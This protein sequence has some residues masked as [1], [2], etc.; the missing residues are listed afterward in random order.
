MSC[1]INC[2]NCRVTAELGP[3]CVVSRLWRNMFQIKLLIRNFTF[4]HT[5]THSYIFL[6]LRPC[7]FWRAARGP[8]KETKKKPKNEQLWYDWLQLWLITA[9]EAKNNL[10]WDHLS[11]W[12]G[13]FYR[14]GFY[15]ADSM[16]S[17]S[18]KANTSTF[19]KFNQILLTQKSIRQ[20]SKDN[21]SLK[22]HNPLLF[23][24][25]AHTSG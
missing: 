21:T 8:K 3:Q 18:L 19:S 6:G 4:T 1:S 23:T 16:S 15:E 20:S 2:Y 17:M 7:C 9:D 24:S 12:Y 25:T 14:L 5:N 10:M 22:Y 13:F 11:D